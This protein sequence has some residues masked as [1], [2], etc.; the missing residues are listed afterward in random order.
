[1][2]FLAYCRLATS[3][4]DKCTGRALVVGCKKYLSPAE[5]ALEARN[6]MSADEALG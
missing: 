2:A 4:A 1:M 6:R 3:N 5:A